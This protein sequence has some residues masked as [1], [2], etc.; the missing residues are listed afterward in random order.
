ME[1]KGKEIEN[2]PS[3]GGW[4]NHPKVHPAGHAIMSLTQK[5]KTKRELFCGW[6]A[7]VGRTMGA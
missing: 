5:V 6:A 1:M 4:K 2:G 3:R 7:R